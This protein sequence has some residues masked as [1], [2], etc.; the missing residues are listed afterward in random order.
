MAYTANDAFCAITDVEA[1]VGRG[2]Y[3][4]STV[5]TNQQ[6]LDWMARRAAQVEARLANGGQAYTVQ[7]R[8][9]AF[10]GSPSAVVGRLKILCEV[11]NAHGA[12]ADAILM[13]EVKLPD[14]VPSAAE[15]LLKAYEDD[16]KQ[17]D[18]LCVDLSRDA[19]SAV[20]ISY[21]TSTEDLEFGMD[22]RW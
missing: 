1:L 17:I 14:G 12:A 16:L 18:L 20:S 22:E 21:T 19:S 9:N 2:A 8:G 13:H 10:P 7:S 15:V 11:A 4:V 6:V 5:P 3:S